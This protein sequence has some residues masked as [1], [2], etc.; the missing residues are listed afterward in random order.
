VTIPTPVTTSSTKADPLCNGQLGSMTATFSG[1]TPGYECSLDNG[2]FAACTSPSTFNNLAA[3]SHTINVRDSQGCSGP[4]QTKTIVIP[5]AVNGSVATTPASSANAADGTMTVTVSG[6]TPG[7]S[8][9]LNGGAPH[10]IATSGGSTTFTGL[11]SGGYNV[12]ITDANGCSLGIAEQLGVAPATI[13][14]RLCTILSSIGTGGKTT[15]MVTLPK[16]ALAQ[17]LTVFYTTSGTAI[18]GVDYSLSGIFGQITIPAGQT[19]ATVTITALANKARRT[20][21]TA[22]LT[23]I[24]GPGYFATLQFNKATV[25]IRR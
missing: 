25:T 2:S 22:T 9:T 18:F 23:I 4:S 16:G 1:G 5:T 13:E 10:S 20:N 8:V 6:G 17:P 15:F 24:N 11:T 14:A 19:S 12:N 21:R 7:Y 3:G